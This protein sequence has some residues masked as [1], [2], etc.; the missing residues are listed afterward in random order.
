[1][2][3]DKPIGGPCSPVPPAAEAFQKKAKEAFDTGGPS[4]KVSARDGQ[5]FDRTD[6]L[7]EDEE[8]DLAGVV[9]VADSLTL[10]DGTELLSDGGGAGRMA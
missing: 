7:T 10:G 9:E 5:L 1:M 3:H 2:A 6:L 4:S 8:R